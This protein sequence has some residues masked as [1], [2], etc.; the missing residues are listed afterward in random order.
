MSGFELRFRIW[1]FHGAIAIAVITQKNMTSMKVSKRNIDAEIIAIAVAT[2]ALCGK[3]FA[4]NLPVKGRQ[5]AIRKPA[6]VSS[7][8]TLVY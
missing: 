2:R 7:A 1:V 5:H 6:C 4:E 8:A 3:F